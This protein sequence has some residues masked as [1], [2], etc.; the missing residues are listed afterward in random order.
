MA[1]AVGVVVVVVVVVVL[2][3]VNNHDVGVV[4]VVVLIF[5]AVPSGTKGFQQV[6]WHFSCCCCCQPA[7]LAASVGRQVV[8]TRP[9]RGSG[10]RAEVDL[11]G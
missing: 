4:I 8:D 6:A 3:G 2:D 10:A 9:N 5:V 1:S 11:E 7:P